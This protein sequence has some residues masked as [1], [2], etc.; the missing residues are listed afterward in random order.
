M[1]KVLLKFTCEG[2][3]SGNQTLYTIQVTGLMSEL[4]TV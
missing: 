2:F 1:R 3:P 4:I